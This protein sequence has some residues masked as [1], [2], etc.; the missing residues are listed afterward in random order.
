MKTLKLIV[1][2]E[3]AG[4]RL[5]HFLQ[6]HLVEFSRSRIQDWIRRGRVKV[7]GEEAKASATVREGQRIVAEPADLPPLEA[8]AEDL[9]VSVLY[10]DDEVIAVDKPA[11]M[12]VHAGAGTHSGTLVNALVH[13]FAKL[14]SVSGQLRPGIVHRIDKDTSGV[15]LVAKTDEA[16]RSLAAQFAGRSV[17]KTYVALVCGRIKD[18]QGR[19]STPIERDPRRRIRMSAKSGKG[20]AALTEY[21]VIRRFDRHTLVEV[22]IHTGRTHQIRV[23][24]SSIGHPVAGDVLYGAPKGSLGRHFLH[25]H[26]LVFTSPATGKRVEVVSPLAPELEGWLQGFL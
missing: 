11:G 25:A 4:Q 18:D 14:S 20:R 23:H 6:R 26:R 21:L 7:D 3:G 13:R 10:E 9:P 1:D 5:D 22:R 16:H 24:L 2:G 17:E 12:A 19:I 8:F 15:L